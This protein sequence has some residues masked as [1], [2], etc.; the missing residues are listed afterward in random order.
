MI[1]I[2]LVAVNIKEQ[3]LMSCCLCFVFFFGLYY[4][5]EFVCSK[6][7]IN[8]LIKC[9]YLSSYMHLCKLKTFSIFVTID[10]S[11]SLPLLFLAIFVKNKLVFLR[12]L[13][14]LI[15]Q[16]VVL[17]ENVK[18][19]F[20]FCNKCIISK[21]NFKRCFQI[22]WIYECT[23]YQTN[24]I[25]NKENTLIIPSQQFMFQLVLFS[26]FLT[27]INSVSDSVCLESKHH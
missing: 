18:T 4:K 12:R 22:F 20:E 10:K 8:T 19:I 23:L 7:K 15:E 17:C 24:N 5:M 21:I 6:N 14:S 3:N 26:L 9:K 2:T 1:S 25:H 27:I 16:K 13:K 11:I